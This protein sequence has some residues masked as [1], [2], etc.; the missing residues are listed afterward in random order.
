[1]KT[2]VLGALGLAL[3][4]CVALP[5]RDPEQADVAEITFHND[6]SGD[7]TAEIF[8]EADDCQVR[9]QTPAIAPGG[10]V[11]AKLAAGRP[12]SFSLGYRVAGTSE[13]NCRVYATFAPQQH[14]RYEAY[15]RPAQDGCKLALLE[16]TDRKVGEGRPVTYRQREP[17][18]APLTEY[19]PYCR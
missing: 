11:S 3:A 16:S 4:G 8:A 19:S 12:L 14:A 7:G 17:A 13:K 2:V 5:Y 9:R 15:I 1:M 10:A 18:S 6:G